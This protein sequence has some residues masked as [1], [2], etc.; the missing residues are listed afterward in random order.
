MDSILA[1]LQNLLPADFDISSFSL[2]AAS[3]CL[4]ALAIAGLGRLIFGKCCLLCRSVSALIGILFIYVLTVTIHTLSL[5]LEF[6]LSPLPFVSISGQT[7]QILSIAGADYTAVCGEVLSML[8][9]AFLVNVLNGFLDRG[10]R[11]LSWLCFHVLAVVLGMA[12][13]TAVSYLARTLLPADIPTYAPAILLGIL[14]IAFILAL[15][16]LIFGVVFAPLVAVWGF[17]FD[18]TGGQYL[19]RAMLTTALFTG[20]IYAL[21][22]FGCTALNVGESALGAY[23]PFLAVLLGLWYLI[24][25][26]F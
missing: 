9:L 1:F 15:L 7:L 10:K 8:V 4:A 17:F 19:S 23:V 2:T 22:C 13:H 24:G 14:V 3:I 25:K 6:L 16:K 12:V 11:V 20:G 5:N 18:S 26:I 21:G